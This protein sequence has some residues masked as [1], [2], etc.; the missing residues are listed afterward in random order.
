M[1]IKDPD[2]GS[3][4]RVCRANPAEGQLSCYDYDTTGR[5]FVRSVSYPGETRSDVGVVQIDANAYWVTGGRLWTSETTSIVT[6][7]TVVF[8]SDGEALPG[9]DLE[10]PLSLHCITRLNSASGSIFIHG[11]IDADG[12]VS[13]RAYMLDVTTLTYTRLP[14]SNFEYQNHACANLMRDSGDGEDIIV[15]GGTDPETGNN[16]LVERFNLAT[17]EWELHPPFPTTDPHTQEWL[18]WRTEPSVFYI[19]GPKDDEGNHAIF[20][21]DG[22]DRNFIDPRGLVPTVDGMTIEAPDI[23]E[24]AI[25]VPVP[26]NVIE[27]C[28]EVKKQQET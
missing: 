3:K 12:R 13:K 1:L 14:D 20:L 10:E 26:S 18:I 11:G 17:R 5:T 6:A 23:D 21:Y 15:I 4:V 25:I 16:N 9:P 27:K 2:A 19:V 24:G 22:I 8:N 7:T 28:T